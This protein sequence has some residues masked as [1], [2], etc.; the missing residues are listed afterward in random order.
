[1]LQMVCGD[2]ATWYVE[3]RAGGLQLLVIAGHDGGVVYAAGVQPPLLA[4]DLLR[5]RP[6]DCLQ[7]A[8]NSETHE[9]LTFGLVADTSVCIAR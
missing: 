6:H 7:Q 9:F 5:Q 2:M 8:H 3:V 4:D 1:M